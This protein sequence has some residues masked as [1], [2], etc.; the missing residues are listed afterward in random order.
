[1]SEVYIA[2]H[3]KFQQG[4]RLVLTLP[5]LKRHRRVRLLSEIH[6]VAARPVSAAS[7]TSRQDPRWRGPIASDAGTQA[8]YHTWRA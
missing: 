8:H 7:H 4:E 5:E 1:M 2:P 6:C 3:L